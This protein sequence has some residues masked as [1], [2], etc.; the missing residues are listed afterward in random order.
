[1]H[2]TGLVPR[3][4]TAGS[5]AAPILMLGGPG[6]S[7]SQTHPEPQIQVERVHDL[8]TAV[9]CITAMVS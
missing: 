9:D 8:A 4:A 6:W 2:V 1:M 7:R 5:G 3:L